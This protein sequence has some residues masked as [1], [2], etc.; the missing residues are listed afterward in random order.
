MEKSQY[1]SLRMSATTEA[2]LRMPSRM[3]LIRHGE[4]QGNIV[5]KAIKKKKIAAYPEGFNE[6]P[7]REFRLSKRGQEQAK[8]T[9]SWLKT[10]YP[11]GFDIIYV[12]DHIR[13]RETAALVCESAGWHDCQIRIDPLLGERSWGN[14]QTAHEHKRDALMALRKRDPLHAAFPDGESLL[15]TRLRAR[16]LIQKA[17]TQFADK[18][19]LIFS[20]GEYIEAFWSEL[21][22][23]STEKSVEFFHS[24]AGNVRNCQVVE[25]SNSNPHTL[26]DEGLLRWV[27]SS[28]PYFEIYGQWSEL[29]YRKFNPRELLEMVNKY[30]HLDLGSLENRE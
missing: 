18:R 1:G 28:C 11:N 9:G 20:H 17:A 16:N 14:F 27:K 8:T 25:F 2:R 10:Q 5:Q 15:F 12:S 4:S 3:V 7:D 21:A 30:P 19:V 24:N 22:H 13:A 29:S 23:W 26:S 6:V